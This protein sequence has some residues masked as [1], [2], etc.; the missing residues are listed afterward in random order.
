MHPAPKF[1]EAEIIAAG[2]GA[3]YGAIRDTIF[4]VL[5]NPQ[6]FSA[7][8]DKEPELKPLLNLIEIIE[9]SGF[10]ETILVNPG[11]VQRYIEAVF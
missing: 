9:L 4:S 8:T 7:F 5:N 11:V 2:V 1:P 3:I 6:S 10:A